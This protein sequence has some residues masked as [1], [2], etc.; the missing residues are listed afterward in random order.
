MKWSM[1]SI[2]LLVVL[3]VCVY[4]LF[5]KQAYDS[6]QK[7]R[8]RNQVRESFFPKEAPLYVNNL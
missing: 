3:S 7:Q 4:I 8:E 5:Q 2:L 1:L 6:P